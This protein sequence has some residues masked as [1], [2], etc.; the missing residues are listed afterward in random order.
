[1]EGGEEGSCRLGTAL[2]LR[3]TDDKDHSTVD[4][5]QHTGSLRNTEPLGSLREPQG[6]SG[7]NFLQ[8]EAT[9]LEFSHAFHNKK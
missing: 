9:K 2:T 6:A 4:K 3:Q 7:I 8:S 1:V 5:I